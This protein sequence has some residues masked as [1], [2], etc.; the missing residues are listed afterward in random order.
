MKKYNFETNEW[1][2]KDYDNWQFVNEAKGNYKTADL[3]E[4]F[5]EVIPYLSNRRTAIDI[6]ARFGCYTRGSTG[7]WFSTYSCF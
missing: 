4:E 7:F 5:A 1:S 6:G 2:Q 3:R